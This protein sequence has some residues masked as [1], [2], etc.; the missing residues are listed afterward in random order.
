M[1]KS[2]VSK[3]KPEPHGEHLSGEAV[4]VGMQAAAHIAQCLGM[5]AADD[6]GRQGEL[7][8]A[9]KLPLHWSTPVEGVVSRLVLDKKRAGSRQRW[10]LAE[11]IGAG[12]IR[13]DVPA[14]VVREGVE[15]IAHS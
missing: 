13:D 7:L 1:T 9:L 12:A 8:R 5:L 3:G 2:K 10:A 14:E 15:F 6:A 4:A 11:G